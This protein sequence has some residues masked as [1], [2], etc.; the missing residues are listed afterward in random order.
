MRKYNYKWG[1]LTVAKD[2]KYY[3]IHDEDWWLLENGADINAHHHN[4]TALDFLVGNAKNI[5]LDEF[6]AKDKVYNEQMR[7]KV[8]TFLIE[9]GAKTMQQ[10]KEEE[11]KNEDYR[12][13]LQRMA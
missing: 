1:C 2:G 7:A 5:L 9:H 3:D 4:L 8:T 6:S 13:E 11:A 12:V 10:I